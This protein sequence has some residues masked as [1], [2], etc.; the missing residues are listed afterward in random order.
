MKLKALLYT[1]LPCFAMAACSD[2]PVAETPEKQET[3][4][5]ISYSTDGYGAG[6]LSRTESE[7]TLC[8]SDWNEK[9]IE[10]L[11]FYLLDA[12][13]KVTF[14]KAI[15]NA[16]SNDC[17][18]THTLLEFKED[19]VSNV[20][21]LDFETL[22]AASQVA[23]VANHD[24]G[25][26][27]ER[28]GKDFKTLYNSAV[29]WTDGEQMTRKDNFIMVG[30]IKLPDQISRYSN[31]V[32]PLR[33]VAA[34]IRLSLLNPNGSYTAPADFTSILCRYSLRAQ[35]LP[36][37]RMPYFRDDK[38]A[39]PGNI[40]PASVATS[41]P[42]AGTDWSYPEDIPDAHPD[43]MV[44]ENGHVYYTYPSDWVNY[45]KVTRQCTRDGQTGHKNHNDG[46]RYEVTDLDDTPCINDIRE[47]FLLIKAP[48]NGKFYF[49]RV[50]VNYRLPSINDQQCYSA[51]D[52]TDIVFA[53]YR[54]ERNHFYD[55]TAFID[56]EG[57]DSPEQ[58]VDPAFTLKV[59]PMTDGGTYDYIYDGQ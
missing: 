52:L 20:D 44:R 42:F 41:G 21:G 13:G 7:E 11:D 15:N 14:Y 25:N 58:A 38:T 57:A 53:L 19:G 50:P 10:T 6:L 29:A 36:D 35:V 48:Y 43:N 28:V 27:G 1:I 54:A 3:S 59:A 30:T 34:K 47:M 22:D 33:R 9:L 2:D 17:N 39:N 26:I 40:F 5:T 8:W 56:R 45:T 51:S 32:V 37:D 46:S 18:V 23:L 49:Y 55:I 24:L 12:A 16:G 31:I 4:F